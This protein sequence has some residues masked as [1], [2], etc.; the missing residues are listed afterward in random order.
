MKFFSFIC[1]IELSVWYIIIVLNIHYC[2]HSVLLAQSAGALE[3][4]DCFS[5]ERLDPH[6]MSVLD[7]TLNNL[8]VRL[9]YPAPDK[10]F[11]I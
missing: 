9:Q 4:T 7:M 10:L 8:I 2:I 6:P 5:A 3:Y 1:S 11:D